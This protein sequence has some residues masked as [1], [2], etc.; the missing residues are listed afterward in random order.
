MIQN[1]VTLKQLR[2]NADGKTYLRGTLLEEIQKPFIEIP[3][4]FQ[5]E[6]DTARNGY[7]SFRCICISFWGFG[8]V[9]GYFM[10]YIF[11]GLFIISRFFSMVFPLIALIYLEF[12]VK[13]IQLLQWI[14]TIAYVLLIFGW[15]IAVIRCLDYYHWTSHLVPDGR[16]WETISYS[17]S[18]KEVMHQY[19][20]LNL[21]QE[22]YN[23]RLSEKYLEKKRKEIVIEILGKDII[24]WINC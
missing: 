7:T 15:I 11:L 24:W 14:L 23:K 18:K 6:F 21:I 4:Y 1:G 10:V 12:D 22:F 2:E 16:W 5:E 8:I 13:S 19:D 3:K 20:R 9:Y 17:A